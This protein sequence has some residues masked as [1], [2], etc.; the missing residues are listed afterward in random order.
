MSRIANRQ[1]YE[2]EA[3][4]ND[5]YYGKDVAISDL[6]EG[7]K[8]SSFLDSNFGYGSAKKRTTEEHLQRDEDI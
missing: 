3:K 7:S 6:D 8:E 2:I 5:L 4:V 1:I